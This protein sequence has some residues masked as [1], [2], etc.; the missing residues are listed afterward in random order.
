MSVDYKHICLSS[1]Y[2]FE[3]QLIVCYLIMNVETSNVKCTKCGKNYSVLGYKRCEKCKEYEKEYRELNREKLKKYRKEYEDLNREKVKEYGKKWKREYRKNNPEKAEKYRKQY[4]Q[5]NLHSI[6]EKDHVRY[7]NNIK[8]NL[9]NS[10]RKRAKRY[11]LA[12]NIDLDYIDSI[13]VKDDICPIMM[14]KM[15]VG[16]GFDKECSFSLDRKIPKLGYIKG[17]IVVI[18]FKANRVKSD[19]LKPDI[20]TILK[21]IEFVQTQHDI[22]D[23][24]MRTIIDKRKEAITRLGACHNIRYK[25]CAIKNMEKSLYDRAKKRAIKNNIEFDLDVDYIKSIWAL[26]NK[27]PYLGT[28]FNSSGLDY[29]TS[30]SI[31]RIDPTKGYIKGNIQIVSSRF[32]TA[33]NNITMIELESALE[34][35]LLML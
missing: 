7:V 21:N 9:L 28:D 32:N 14:V 6:K 15:S 30:P 23:T 18:C 13:W 29:K 1:L 24:T 33:K 34:R 35:I 12:F 2:I 10:A 19:L 16:R 11:G 26:D 17:N 25:K 27:C 3:N 22:D 20:E 8:K 31:D 4:Y 5:D